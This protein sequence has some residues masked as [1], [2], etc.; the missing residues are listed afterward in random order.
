MLDLYA[1]TGS[2][3]IEALSRGAGRAVFVERSR[4][5]LGVLRRN[6]REL[7]LEAVSR[8][9]PLDVRQ[10]AR[11]LRAEGER[12]QLVLADPPYADRELA[13]PLGT[14]VS[15]G[16]LTVDAVVVVER[17]RRHPLQEIPGLASIDAR[18]YGDTVIEWLAPIGNEGARGGPSEQGESQP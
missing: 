1:G 3:G 13:G 16:L 9:L 11:R 14:L 12:F 10:A 7:E 15:E 8:V 4:A 18:R 2:L 6:L 5:A 17:S